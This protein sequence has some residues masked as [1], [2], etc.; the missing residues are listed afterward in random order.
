MPAWGGANRS[1]I[2]GAVGS[3]GR[4]LEGGECAGS[5]QMTLATMWQESMNSP[6]RRQAGRFPVRIAVLLEQ[7]GGRTRDLSAVGM[8]LETSQGLGEVGEF[9]PFRLVFGDPGGEQ[10]WVL[11]CRGTIL[12][13]EALAVGVGVAVQILDEGGCG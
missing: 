7:A 13:T 5:L 1:R 8:Y 4:C 3:V 9:L 12:R 6:D 2:G 11:C 10:S